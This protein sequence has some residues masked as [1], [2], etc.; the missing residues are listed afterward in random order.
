[1]TRPAKPKPRKIE[2]PEKYPD[3]VYYRRAINCLNS[4]IQT[5]HTLWLQGVITKGI[6]D[7]LIYDMDAALEYLKEHPAEPVEPELD[8]FRGIHD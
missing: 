3:E 1:M 4:S 7:R 2:P 5:A 6:R 8:K